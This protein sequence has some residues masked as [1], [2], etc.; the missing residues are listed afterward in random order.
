MHAGA[1]ET[2]Y[3]ESGELSIAYQVIGSGPPDLLYVGS[4]VN[5]I[6]H[7]WEL[8]SYARFL[9]RLASFSRVITLDKRGSGLS[10]RLRHFP[11]QRL[12]AERDARR[13]LEHRVEQLEH[14]RRRSG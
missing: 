10:D 11:S 4:W 8:P 9:E 5:Q 3:A 12:G 2:R 14:E 6:E 7:A 1:P 13:R